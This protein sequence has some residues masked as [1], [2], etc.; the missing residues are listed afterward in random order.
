[1]NQM[2]RV[3]T[4][5]KNLDGILDGGFPS[6]S[7][8]IIAGP[9]GSGKTVLS[10]QIAFNNAGP[11]SKV[12]CFTTISEPTMKL[13][14]YQQQFTYFDSQKI[15][16]SVIF[17]D[18]GQ[19]IRTKGLPEAMGG[20]LCSVEEHSPSI[21]VVD[22]FKAIQDLVQTELE[23]RKF[24]YDLCVKLTSWECIAFF[25]G[26]YTDE[27]MEQEPIFAIADGIVTLS[28]RE[29]G[30]QTIRYIE[31]LKM[32]GTNYF[33]GKHPVTI[34]RDG[35]TIYP[36]VTTPPEPPVFKIAQER[37]STGIPGLDAMF[38]GG[39]PRGTATLV[40]G[41]SGTGKTLFGLHFLMAGVAAGEP[42]VFVTF[43]ET[44]SPLKTTAKNFGWELEKLE[45]EK[46]IKLMYTSPVEL[47]VDEHSFLIRETIREMG[48]KRLVV[49]NL[50]GIEIATPDKVRYKD[51]V[52]SLV[53]FLQSRGV[54]SLLTNEVPELFGSFQLTSYSVSFITDN[55]IL[56][57]Y[58]EVESSVERAL[59]VLKSRG[60]AHD[61]GIREYLIGPKGIEIV[62]K[63]LG[64]TGVLGEAPSGR[65]KRVTDDIIQPLV[66]TQDFI[67]MIME[68]KLD[69]E[70][71][72][73]VL[74]KV[75]QQNARLTELICDYFGWDSSKLKAEKIHTWELDKQRG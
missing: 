51:F 73:E 19:V 1:M 33:S 58:V 13:I 5:V 47:G 9:P 3:K 75:E 62:G 65:L 31:L 61:R 72:Q 34:T 60:C 71:Q 54:T 22:S 23:N 16:S 67:G 59:S 35:I 70:K 55:V 41:G 48:A 27:E 50:M 37:I 44:P 74:R 49:D 68:G 43:Q 36:R 17:V 64:L 28:R 18:I 39:I 57:R 14:K 42:G 29:R 20:I 26:E 4:G 56:L 53:A 45:R 66:S 63:M 52:Y 46:K 8:N 12:L 2:M 38:L 11:K 40:A 24:A 15:G 32:R 10:Q 69:K 7:V 25:V 21:V 6:Y 30:M